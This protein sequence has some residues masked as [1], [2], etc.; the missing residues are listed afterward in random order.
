MT[1]NDNVNIGHLGA[2]PAHLQLRRNVE[3]NWP[4]VAQELLTDATSAALVRAEHTSHLGF[5]W[6]SKIVK[7]SCACCA[8][9]VALLRRI[10]VGSV[11]WPCDGTMSHYVSLS[12]KTR[13]ALQR[14]ISFT[15]MVWRKRKRPRHVVPRSPSCRHFGNVNVNFRALHP[16]I[17]VIMWSCWPRSSHRFTACIHISLHCYLLLH[18]PTITHL[19]TLCLTL[20]PDLMTQVDKLTLELDM[21]WTW[22]DR[23]KKFQELVSECV[24][25]ICGYAASFELVLMK[26]MKAPE[27]I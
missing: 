25:G 24:Q 11:G 22:F 27:K 20:E 23:F 14:N 8:C 6:E 5:D 4:Q 16:W 7:N 17:C 26:W 9:C 3:F 10:P 19:A 2:R 1:K 15:S 12:N 18:A 13:S 21:G